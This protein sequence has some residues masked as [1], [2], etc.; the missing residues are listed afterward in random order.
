MGKEESK[1]LIILK[2]QKQQVEI[3]LNQQLDSVQNTIENLKYKLNED[4][5]YLSK[6]DGLQSNGHSIDSLL[7]ELVTLNRAI[8]LFEREYNK[9]E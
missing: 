2:S 4:Q 8:E 9:T 1:N 7:S 6:S 5:E 3:R